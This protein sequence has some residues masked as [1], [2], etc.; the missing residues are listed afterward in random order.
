MTVADDSLRTCAGC[1]AKVHPREL[2][3]FVFVPDVGVLHDL[4][5]KAPGR[6]AHVHASVGCLERA[7]ASGFKRAFKMQL[8]PIE[9]AELVEAVR[10]A[11][12]KRLEEGAVVAVRSRQAAV[13]QSA[14]VDAM[15]RDAAELVLLASDAGDAAQS[16]F[17]S[18]AE[19]KRLKLVDGFDGATL[20]T[21][22]GKEF[23]SVLS[24]TGAAAQ[25][26]SRDVESLERLGFF[27]G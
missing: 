20:G 17:R 19:R 2:E 24:V 14:V 5:R 21:W 27:E 22:A 16:K 23:V 13:G 25:R 26:L 18:N 12:A 4:R 11:V 15:K 1:G 10:R 3:R 6:G 9:A 8:Q 7:A